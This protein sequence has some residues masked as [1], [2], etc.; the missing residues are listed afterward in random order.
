MNTSRLSWILVGLPVF[1]LL[2]CIGFFWY[3]F[4]QTMAQSKQE[5][6]L[7]QFSIAND[8]SSNAVVQVLSSDV[9]NRK[10]EAALTIREQIVEKEHTRFRAELSTWLSIFGLLTILV[11][12]IA[13]VCSLIFQQKEF[14]RL[15]KLID[16]QSKSIEDIKM[17]RMEIEHTAK[18]VASTKQEMDN[19]KA[20]TDADRKEEEQRGDAIFHDDLRLLL[21]HFKDLWGMDK[22]DEKIVAGIRFFDECNAR[23]SSAIDKNHPNPDALKECLNMLNNA[24]AYLGMGNLAEFRIRFS[25]RM[26]EE[27]PLKNSN[28]EIV[29]ALKE[30]NI[31]GPITGFYS[32]ALALQ[33]GIPGKVAM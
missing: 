28:D 20:S 30:F 3:V 5:V 32:S 12:L 31:D 2:V 15:Q 6:P 4:S 19:E 21:K 29:S 16:D 33:G 10:V 18:Q 22:F 17:W 23:I 1:V 27:H 24:R 11:S 8:C 13:P 14:D 9:V 25:Q 7:V 26:Q